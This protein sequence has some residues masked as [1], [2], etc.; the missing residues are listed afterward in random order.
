MTDKEKDT[1]RALRTLLEQG[2]HLHSL[3]A[4]GSRARGDADEDSDLDVLVVS[5]EP[6][7]HELR[8]FVYDCAYEAGLAAGMLV[9]AVYFSRDRWENGPERAS[10][11]AMAIRRE[12]IAI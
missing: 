2:L 3:V 6:E 9:N 10:L 1:L 4:F 7:T 8:M 12:G 11:L 5:E